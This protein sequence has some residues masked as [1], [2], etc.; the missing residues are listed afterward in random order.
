MADAKS[1]G[2]WKR[3]ANDANAKLT[4]ADVIAIRR[5]YAKFGRDAIAAQYGIDYRTAWKV[6]TR[7]A[8]K[9]VD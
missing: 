9:H 7:R 8:W 2:T 5:D 6:A 3:G 4:E 1:H